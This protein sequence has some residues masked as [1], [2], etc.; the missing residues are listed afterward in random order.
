MTRKTVPYKGKKYHYYYCPTTKKRGC[1]EG[2]NL[3]EDDLSECI[4]E[5][6]K[7]H[8]AN[9]ASMDSIIASSDGQRMAKALIEQYTSQIAENERQL[10][11]A[12]VFKST[13]YEN[14]IN[15]I[16]TKDDYKTLKT[17]YTADENQL[18][19]AIAAL[20][21]EIENVLAGKGERLRWTEHFKRFDGLDKL[22]R[23]V[24]VNLIQSIRIV[25]KT[26]LV[27][28]FNYQAEYENVLAL[29]QKEV[30]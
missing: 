4:L 23:R 11:Q 9:V 5:S 8:I 26:E 30:A 28:T 15:N 13:L 19:D 18:R 25:G 6:V 27:I 10:E 3:K 14:M 2:V 7:A 12:R 21:Q 20:S 24:V 22:D 29:L 16:I 1:T 17:K